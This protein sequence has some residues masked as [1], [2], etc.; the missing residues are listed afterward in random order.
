MARKRAGDFLNILSDPEKSTGLLA[1]STPIMLK[2]GQPA[3]KPGNFPGVIGL[4]A[5][6]GTGIP[7]KQRKAILSDDDGDGAGGKFRMD[8]ALAALLGLLVTNIVSFTLGAR[9]GRQAMG[10]ETT[11]ALVPAEMEGATTLF[12]PGEQSAVST[13]QPPT[14]A[15]A[16]P[17]QPRPPVAE[18]GPMPLS[19]NAVVTPPAAPATATRTAPAPAPA[20]AAAPVSMKGKY[21]V[22]LITLS[23]DA[24]RQALAQK[25]KAYMQSNG[26]PQ[27]IVRTSDGK[28]VVEVGAFDRYREAIPAMNTIRKMRCGYERFDSA[29]VIQRPK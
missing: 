9:A 18:T 22:R 21:V 1:G 29:Y 15:T 10:P 26:F 19:G 13:P 27:C 28:L 8:L 4:G 20:P 2:A 16:T 12:T 14:S 24:R 3:G 23:Y 25:I 17:V 11:T 6:S 5:V 7:P